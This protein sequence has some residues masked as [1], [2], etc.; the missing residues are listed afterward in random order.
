MDAALNALGQTREALP[1]YFTAED[2]FSF[3][4]ANGMTAA[5]IAELALQFQTISL[6]LLQ[7]N[8]NWEELF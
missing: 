8:R 3:A 6:N 4:V 2:M 5:Q 1:E 7:N